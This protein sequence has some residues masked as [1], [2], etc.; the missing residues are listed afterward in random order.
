MYTDH[1]RHCHYCHSHEESNF[2]YENKCVYSWLSR[3]NGFK[4]ISKKNRVKLLHRLRMWVCVCVGVN[5]VFC[6]SSQHVASIKWCVKKCSIFN[7]LMPFRHTHFSSLS[8]FFC[9]TWSHIRIWHLIRRRFQ[10]YN[11]VPPHY[12]LRSSVYV[13]ASWVSVKENWCKIYTIQSTTT[14]IFRN[15]FTHIAHPY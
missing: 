6:S 8:L 4:W 9:S 2:M 10:I 1:C 11:K 5:I 15:H 13:A 14:T 3:I 7:G 12:E